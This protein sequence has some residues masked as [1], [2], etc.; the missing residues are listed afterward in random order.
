MYIMQPFKIDNENKRQLLAEITRDICQLDVKELISDYYHGQ[1]PQTIIDQILSHIKVD[2]T[3][4]LA[5]EKADTITDNA[6]V[7][8]ATPTATNGDMTRTRAI[9]MFHTVG[10]ALNGS[11]DVITFASKNKTSNCYWANPDIT[12]LQHQFWLI[13][14]DHI[15][16]KLFLFQ[17]PAYAIDKTQLITR[18]D[19]P[20]QF[21]LQIN[22]G[23]PSFTDSRSHFSFKPFLVKEL[24]Y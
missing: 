22:Y 12:C 21:D 20:H 9:V 4:D 1:Y 7:T 17:I 15:Q 18:T 10:F 23:D 8:P 6:T 5:T 3:I 13:L 11:E 19:K 16:H 24:N 14:N 2:L